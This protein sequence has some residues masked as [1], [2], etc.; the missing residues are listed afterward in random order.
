MP[1]SVMLASRVTFAPQLRG[2]FAGARCPRLDHAYSRCSEVFAPHSS[3][4]TKRSAPTPP[5][6]LTLQAALRNS[7]LSL[8]PTDLFFCSIPG[9]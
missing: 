7:S 2:A 1:E 3:T 4:N 9:A 5:A 6:T 8:A